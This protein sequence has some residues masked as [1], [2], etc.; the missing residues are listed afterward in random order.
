MLHV[1]QVH[2][3]ITVL[4]AYKLIEIRN[5]KAEECIF[6]FWRGADKLKIKNQNL[7]WINYTYAEQNIDF[8]YFLDF[9]VFDFAKLINRRKKI[10]IFKKWIGTIF[11]NKS[12][13]YYTPHINP[14]R[15][16]IIVDNKKCKKLF[17]FE[18]GLMSYH[19][20]DFMDNSLKSHGLINTLKNHIKAI[21]LFKNP[22]YS[23]YSLFDKHK[24]LTKVFSFN[25]KSF[26]S[27]KNR[28][29]IGLPFV[30][31]NIFQ[32]CFHVLVIDDYRDPNIVDSNNYF[33][34]I[35]RILSSIRAKKIHYKPHPSIIANKKDYEKLK[36]FI[37]SQE[38][39]LKIKIVEISQ[40]ISLENLAFTYKEKISFY[41]V[42][43]ATL[44]YTFLCNA[45]TF[46]SLYQLALIDKSFNQILRQ[47][48]KSMSFPKYYLELARKFNFK[49]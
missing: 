31:Q 47:N 11:K 35:S 49:K 33:K 24:K 26:L 25:V 32:E 23:G 34:I 2:S 39:K 42:F 10:K 36:R 21:L 37:S 3:S 15:D 44:L 6:L 13:Y 29:V 40:G 12:Y 16:R 27:F 9:R 8:K 18:E 43:S 4:A 19:S 7:T 41:G 5:I 20:T 1:F 28:E 38:L 46:F 14:V 45:K 30:T 48:N 22:N 17:Y